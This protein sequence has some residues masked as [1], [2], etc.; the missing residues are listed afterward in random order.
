MRR[1]HL[2]GLRV[3]AAYLPPPTPQVSIRV[4][5]EN[6]GES[7]CRMGW[8]GQRDRRQRQK[9]PASKGE[10]RGRVW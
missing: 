9:M 1:L 7:D 4:S 3:T 10:C 2:I 8:D 5:G 6:G